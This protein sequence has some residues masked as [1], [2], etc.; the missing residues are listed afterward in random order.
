[1]KLDPSRSVHIAIVGKKGSG[2]SV[3]S[4]SYWRTWPGDR[5]V[6]D[7]TGDA[8]EGPDREGV[9]TLTDP[10]PSKW[11][12]QLQELAPHGRKRTSLRYVPDPGSPT[13]LADMD[14][15]LGMAYAKGNVLV[16]VDEV[17]ELFPANRTPPY[18]RRALQQGR[19]RNLSLVLAGPRPI[20]VDPLVMSQ[21]DL[22]YVFRLPNPND[23]RR[24]ADLIGWD[25]REFVAYVDQLETHAFLEYDAAAAELTIY[26]PL[27][28]QVAG[29]LPRSPGATTPT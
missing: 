3:L 13:Y 24:V 5:L 9:H 23:K 7:V 25:P 19:H 4:R 16:W 27:P 12:A 6:I 10:L 14:R 20:D 1:V 17:G 18:A 28:P 2:K 11:P 15:A 21:A 8:L 26:P 29:P 22:V